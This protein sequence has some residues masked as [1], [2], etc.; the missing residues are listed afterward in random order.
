MFPGSRA[1]RPA[2]PPWRGRR[3][4]RGCECGRRAPCG[5][6]R[7]PAGGRAG[8]GAAGPRARWA[9]AGAPG[10]PL[11]GLLASQL[12]RSSRCFVII[13]F[14]K[15]RPAG[16]R[17]RRAPR[18]Y[19]GAG[20]AAGAL[21]ACGTTAGRRAA[22]LSP[23]LL[24]LWGGGAESCAIAPTAP[25]VEAAGEAGSGDPGLCSGP[26]G[27]FPPRDNGLR[28]CWSVAAAVA[29][30]GRRSS[31]QVLPPPHR[32]PY[33]PRPSSRQCFALPP[34]GVLDVVKCG[35][36][37]V[38]VAPEFALSEEPIGG[39]G[40]KLN[41]RVFFREGGARATLAALTGAKDGSRLPGR[42]ELSMCWGNALRGWALREGERACPG[43][44][45]VDRRQNRRPHR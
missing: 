44:L 42:D 7:G 28:F 27:G 29:L 35:P 33:L 15:A 43:Q 17:A 11:A 1:A 30:G 8:A 23:W 6:G 13:I 25:D 12:L 3:R 14:V 26:R 39:L 10:R 24:S 38:L 22:I 40:E 5:A 2:P 37:D 18:R 45:P 19:W 34:A 36:E 21:L 41:M 16:G 31:Q 4:A 32:A 9:G 20:A